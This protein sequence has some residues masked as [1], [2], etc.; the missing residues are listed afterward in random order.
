MNNEFIT[1][2]QA[3]VRVS[4]LAGLTADEYHE[5][6]LLS[7]QYYAY[8]MVRSMVLTN[9]SE[10]FVQKVCNE[11][12]QNNVHGFWPFWQNQVYLKSKLLLNMAEQIIYPTRVAEGTFRSMLK[13]ERIKAE[14]STSTFRRKIQ[15]LVTNIAKMEV[16]NVR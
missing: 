16:Q 2:E 4:A 5:L 15:A 6:V 10:T 9:V 13:P 3:F 12:L 7:G 1:P 8:H 11:L 14:P